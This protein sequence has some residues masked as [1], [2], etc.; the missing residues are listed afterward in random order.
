MRIKRNNKSVD[1]ELSMEL[2]EVENDGAISFSSE[3]NEMVESGLKYT[4]NVAANKKEFTENAIRFYYNS[5]SK[6]DHSVNDSNNELHSHVTE[7]NELFEVEGPDDSTRKKNSNV[8]DFVDDVI[9]LW[10]VQNISISETTA[11]YL[12][13]IRITHH[14]STLE[15]IMRADPFGLNLNEL[16]MLLAIKRSGKSEGI[17]PSAIRDSLMISP[18]AISKQIERLRKKGYIERN[19]DINDRR[20]ILVGLTEAGDDLINKLAFDTDKDHTRII[21]N[22]NNK[23]IMV[24]NQI[25]RKLLILLEKQLN[26]MEEGI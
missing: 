15:T 8:A 26:E 25:L 16:H 14:L 23:E 17:T 22:L 21:E 4:A 11:I 10:K 1:N 9:Q 18:G 6:G 19:T 3:I 7:L 5:L 12:R 20:S 13:L 2:N 24:L